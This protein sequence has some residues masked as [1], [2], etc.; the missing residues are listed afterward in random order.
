MN[1]AKSQRRFRS[2]SYDELMA[3]HAICLLTYVAE[4]PYEEQ[5]YNSL[6]RNTGIPPKTIWNLVHW[7]HE[8]APQFG[9]PLYV[10]ALNLGYE[11]NIICGPGLILRVTPK[12]DFCL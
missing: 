5:S 9:E 7:N 2:S 12:E 4:H 1:S 3:N 10:W 11:V 8:K 6:A